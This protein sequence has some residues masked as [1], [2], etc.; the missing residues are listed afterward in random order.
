MNINAMMQQAKKMQDEMATAQKILHAKEFTIEK[1]G[2]TIVMMGDKK[3][4]SIDIDEVLVDPEDKE[5][6]EDLMII[7]FNDAIELITAEEEKNAPS[8]P[9]GMPF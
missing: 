5:L 8:A 2:V 7:A 9:S 4:K 6:L 1:Q 3:I